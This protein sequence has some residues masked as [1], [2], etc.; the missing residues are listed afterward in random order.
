MSNVKETISKTKVELI[1]IQYNEK[2]R[3]NYEKFGFDV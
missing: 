2:K 1:L 3:Y